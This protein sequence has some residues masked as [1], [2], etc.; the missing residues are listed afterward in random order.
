MDR[1][2]INRELADTVIRDPFARP[3]QADVTGTW[4]SR[5]A[6]ELLG[7]RVRDAFILATPASQPMSV[8]GSQPS[9]RCDVCGGLVWMAPSSLA[10]LRDGLSAPVVCTVCLYRGKKAQEGP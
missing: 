1:D 4:I 2:A 9:R 10:A 8:I 3:E 7:D 6:K 5:T